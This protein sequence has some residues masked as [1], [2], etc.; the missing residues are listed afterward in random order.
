MKR[1]D[2]FDGGEGREGRQV[3]RKGLCCCIW[4]RTL[5]IMEVREAVSSPPLPTNLLL[6][7]LQPSSE[8]ALVSQAGWHLASA[9]SCCLPALLVFMD[10]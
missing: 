5:S 2:R 10:H 4:L 9:A 1:E 6:D 7:H 8:P 3:G